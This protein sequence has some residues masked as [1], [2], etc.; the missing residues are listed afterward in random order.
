MKPAASSCIPLRDFEPSLFIPA[1]AF[2]LA[3]F[4]VAAPLAKTE[5]S[6]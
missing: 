1:K 2:A 3:G 6:P 5:G 4:T